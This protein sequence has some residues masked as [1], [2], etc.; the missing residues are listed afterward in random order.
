MNQNAEPA[1]HDA[2]GVTTHA[3]NALP[4][5][6]ARQHKAILLETTGDGSHVVGFVHP[7]RGQDFE[8]VRR[9]LGV[10][11]SGIVKRRL[12]EE[13]YDSRFEQTYNKQQET[14]A[15]SA[16]VTSTDAWA[17]GDGEDVAERAGAQIVE[18]EDQDW[19]IKDDAKSKRDQVLNLCA[20]SVLIR[21]SDLHFTPYGKYGLVQP[22]VDGRLLPPEKC[23][24]YQKED[25]EELQRALISKTSNSYTD[26]IQVGGDGKFYMRIGG[27][28][29]QC[30]LSIAKTVSGLDFCIR[31]NDFQITNIDYLG[32][33]PRQA[34]DLRR[35]AQR[36]R[37]IN[38][39]VGPTGSGKSVAQQ[40]TL[41]EGDRMN[42]GIFEIG[43]PIENRVFGR[44][45]IEISLKIT[46][47]DAYA[48][49]L[50]HDP[51]WL[52]AGE[53]RT[54]EQA[55]KLFQ[56][57]TSGHLIMTT[58]H[59]SSAAETA[60]R[61]RDLGLKAYQIANSINCILAQRL[62]PMLC[63]HCRLPDLSHPGEYLAREGG[64]PQCIHRGYYKRLPV[65]EVLVPDKRIN[66]L[67]YDAA[68]PAEIE[69]AARANGMITLQEAASMKIVRG[70]TSREAV[71]HELGEIDEETL[72]RV[73]RELALA[74]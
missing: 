73:R 37:G 65:A 68:P 35:S 15:L 67:F 59:V 18:E 12:A 52:I 16:W 50:R 36:D 72:E 60:K 43:D 10:P 31:F 29:I 34:H 44:T 24:K 17:D 32:L 42:L 20:S 19:V 62:V 41:A 1:A 71:E 40:A 46:W 47:D 63:P 6:T 45:Q 55:E 26:I 9:A 38:F 70:V 49:G 39:F 23:R 11:R 25:L 61:L 2:A 57:V 22:R 21:A 30:R 54:A 3:L 4:R 8:A 5:D 14:H 66:G 33:E 51:D 64:C 27:R 56:G 58:L 53:V 13:D 48:R 28:L 7:D 69:A 74:A